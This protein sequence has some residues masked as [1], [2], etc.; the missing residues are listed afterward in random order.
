[1]PTTYSRYDDEDD[2][3][4]RIY[5]HR[6]D[7][8]ANL[9]SESVILFARTAN[10]TM[11]SGGF[12]TANIVNTYIEWLEIDEQRDFRGARSCHNFPSD[13]AVIP[14]K[15]L[16]EPFGIHDAFI[17]NRIPENWRRYFDDPHHELQEPVEIYEYYRSHEAVEEDGETEDVGT[18]RSA[19]PDLFEEAGEEEEEDDAY[20]GG[21]RVRTLRGAFGK[22]ET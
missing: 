4:R 15:N 14:H 2:L 9:F 1:M 11:C 10:R 21:R 17:F 3:S 22:W 19:S 20:V 5:L 13:D 7:I 12:I 16:M 18:S 8:V 6:C